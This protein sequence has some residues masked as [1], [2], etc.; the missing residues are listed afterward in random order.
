MNPGEIIAFV[1]VVLI[2]LVLAGDNAV[3]IG[4]LAASVAPSQRRQV[5]L[6]GIGLAILLRIALSLGVVWLLQIP[7]IMLIGG[8]TLFWVAWKMAAE[9]LRPANEHQAALASPGSLGSAMIA[10]VIA[11]LTMSLD[12]VLAVAATAREHTSA[13]VV[14]LM[15][16]MAF[17]GAGAALVAGL[18]AKHRWIVAIGIVLVVFAGVRMSIDG[19]LQLATTVSP[20]SARP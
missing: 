5:I 13:L 18:I 9:A 12:N 15:L 8:L 14:G 16:S 17:M 20:V 3:V 19:I 2:D 7:G 6:Y 4:A 1:R 10:L 11:D